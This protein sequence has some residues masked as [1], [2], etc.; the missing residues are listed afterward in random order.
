V[1]D[2][3]AFNA[4]LAMRGSTRAEA[5]EVMGMNSATL[6]RKINGKSD[7]YRKEITKFCKFYRVNPNEIFFAGDSA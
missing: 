7:F 3:R 2:E 6:F 1:F 4:I 5:A